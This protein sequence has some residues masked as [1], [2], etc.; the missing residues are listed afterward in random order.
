PARSIC[1]ALF[2]GTV[3]LQ[4]LWLFIVAPIAGALIAAPAVRADRADNVLH[5]N[6]IFG[7]LGAPPKQPKDLIG[8]AHG[9]LPGMDRPVLPPWTI[10]PDF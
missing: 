4:Q 8:P 5:V 1:P 7:A 10:Q 2:A 6:D 9:A 3:P